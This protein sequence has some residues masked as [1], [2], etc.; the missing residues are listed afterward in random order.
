MASQCVALIK[1]WFNIELQVEAEWFQ[2]CRP[3]VETEKEG[4]GKPIVEKGT[5]SS[6]STYVDRRFTGGI[7]LHE[8]EV[9][10]E[11]EWFTLWRSRI[12][13]YNVCCWLKQVEWWTDGYVALVPAPSP[14][15]P[16][17]PSPWFSC[18]LNGLRRKCI[19]LFAE[20][21]FIGSRIFLL[22]YNENPILFTRIKARNN[23]H[24]SCPWFPWLSLY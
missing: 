21:D 7:H 11:D 13:H 22:G 17:P 24:S 19:Q 8:N 14:S 16:S 23:I 10:I 6:D 20:F 12:Q 9:E 5:Q 4:K 2:F 1:N 18:V 15:S 3:A